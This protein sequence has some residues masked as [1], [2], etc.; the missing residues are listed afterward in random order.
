[1]RIVLLDDAPD[2]AALVIQSSTAAGDTCHQFSRRIALLH[3]LQR[4]TFGLFVLDWVPDVSRDDLLRWVRR[5]M[6]ERLPVIL[7]P[8]AGVKTTLG[9]Y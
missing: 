6:R 4:R 8:D 3:A 5:S 1:M 7:F 2:Q 9:Q